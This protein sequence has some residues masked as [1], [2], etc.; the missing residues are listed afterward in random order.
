MDGL[1]GVSD[2]EKQLFHELTLAISRELAS[3]VSKTKP[4]VKTKSQRNKTK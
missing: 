4:S 1:P 3:H 2:K